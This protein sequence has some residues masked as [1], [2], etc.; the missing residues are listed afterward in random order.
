MREILF[1]GIPKREADFHFFKIAY[2]M[3]CEG[4]FVIGS[5][6][7]EALTNRYYIVNAILAKINCTV[8]NAQC[9][10][11]E[12]DPDTVGQYIGLK[13][14]NGKKIFEGD[15]IR[16]AYK[17]DYDLCLECEEHPELY[18]DYK[19]GAFDDLWTYDKVKYWENIGY[20]AFDLLNWVAEVN[21]LSDL[22][23]SG[24][25]HFEVI[26][27]FHNNAEPLKGKEKENT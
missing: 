22:H 12:V 17:N 6:L 20:P 7:Y 23:E 10:A 2:P 11:I 14:S 24:D 21:G 18:E 5:L 3:S 9:T 8:G 15:I 26:G 16:Y 4:N 27:S 25:Y 1:R 13:D 19:D